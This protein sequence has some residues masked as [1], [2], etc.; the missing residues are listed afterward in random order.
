M[1][2]EI[3]FGWLVNYKAAKLDILM[4]THITSLHAKDV[5]NTPKH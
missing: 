2:L 5:T 4:F 1:I 3:F